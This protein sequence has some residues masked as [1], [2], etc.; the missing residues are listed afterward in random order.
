[1]IVLAFEGDSTT[2][3]AFDIIKTQPTNEARFPRYVS[4]V[5]S[6]I[7]TLRCAL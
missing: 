4:N 5:T 1:L 7:A 6:K 2:T 3:N